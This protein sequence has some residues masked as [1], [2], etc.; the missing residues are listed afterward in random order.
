MYTT[1]LAYVIA[2]LG[3]VM[4]GVGVLGLLHLSREENRTTI[5]FRDYG[6]AI[7]MICAGF[8]MGG[9]AQ[10]LRVLVAIATAIQPLH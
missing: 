6:M 5:P 9:V 3:L 7:A 8:G 4:I 1:M 2:F 10:A